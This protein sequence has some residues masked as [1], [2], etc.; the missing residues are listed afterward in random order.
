[1]RG[2]LETRA[3][4]KNVDGITPCPACDFA[5]FVD[6]GVE[7][8]EC[9]NPKCLKS[10]C[11]RC[12]DKPH[13]SISCVQAGKQKATATAADAKADPSKL[14]ESLR[15][16]V[17]DAVSEAL[18]RRC[19]DCNAP[20]VKD[21]GCN[22]M[23]CIC[24]NVTCYA[25]KAQHITHDHWFRTSCVHF[26][27]TEA[28]EEQE[29]KKAERDAIA[30]V[31][32]EHPGSGLKEKDLKVGEVSEAVKR[33]DRKKK[34]REAK[35]M[36]GELWMPGMEIEGGDEDMMAEMQMQM[37]GVNFAGPPAGG[38]GFNRFENARAAHHRR[39]GIAAVN[40]VANRGRG[41]MRGP[42]RGERENFQQQM[43]AARLGAEH[44]SLAGAGQ[45]ARF[46]SPVTHM[47][48]FGDDPFFQHQHGFNDQFRGH[49]AFDDFG[50]PLHFDEEGWAWEHPVV[51]PR[52]EEVRERQMAL[53]LNGGRMGHGFVPPHAL[54]RRR[55]PPW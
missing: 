16:K 49:P 12:K 27:S 53:F 2:R 46:A 40:R 42:T 54:G 13:P 8:F 22:E 10:F 4:L 21:T 23:R 18:I 51:D 44:D 36:R 43:A 37:A 38:A 17:E 45:L 24:G 29:R 35:E 28:R 32:R 26:E 6:P 48:G 14:L 30:R 20:F 7:V 47:H 9:R 15:R 1:M 52:L 34:V 41:V 11:M 3:L 33:D 5:A 50:Q 19:A 31:L 25:C 55:R 39:G